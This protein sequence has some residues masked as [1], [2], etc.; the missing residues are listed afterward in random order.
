MQS[1][2]DELLFFLEPKV[3]NLYLEY[4]AIG[5]FKYQKVLFFTFISASFHYFFSNFV[6]YF[7]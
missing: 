4:E 3:P 6:T 7:Y 1:T 5:I 2:H